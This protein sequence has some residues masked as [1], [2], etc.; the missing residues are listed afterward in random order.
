[1]QK[2]TNQEGD[3]AREKEKERETGPAVE[4]RGY[5]PVVQSTGIPYGCRFLSQQPCFQSN[6]ACGL[7]KQLRITQSLGA[8]HLRARRG[9][10]SMS[11]FLKIAALAVE[12][13]CRVSASVEAISASLCLLLSIYLTFQSK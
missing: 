6:S 7:A 4:A 12:G 1:M 2:D 13:P 3:R 5:N 9:S 10:G 11:L 8:L